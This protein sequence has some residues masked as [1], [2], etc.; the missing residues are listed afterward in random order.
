MN[1]Q[2]PKTGRS[3]AYKQEILGGRDVMEMSGSMEPERVTGVRSG[4]MRTPLLA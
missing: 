2:N 4:S 1:L 3:Q